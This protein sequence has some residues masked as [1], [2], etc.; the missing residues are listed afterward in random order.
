MNILTR[1][2]EEELLK[3]FKM[4]ARTN[5]ASLI[6]EFVDCTTGRVVSVAWACRSQLKAMNNCLNKF[7]TQEELDKLRLEYIKQKRQ[8]A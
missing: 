5:C 3:K 2:E 1:A 6:Q 4:N 7:T 8:K